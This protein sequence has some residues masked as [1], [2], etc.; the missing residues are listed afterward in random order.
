MRLVELKIFD[1]RLEIDTALSK[2]D[3]R[4]CFA[5]TVALARLPFGVKAVVKGVEISEK[6]WVIDGKASPEPRLGS[7]HLALVIPIR[8]PKMLFLTSP[9]IVIYG[10]C[11]S[12]LEARRIWR[13]VVRALGVG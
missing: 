2:V 4:E 9:G 6:R 12:R 5:L 7:K 11:Y 1:R 8:L 3:E 10:A 13:E